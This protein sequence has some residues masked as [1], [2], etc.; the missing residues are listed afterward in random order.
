MCKYR[1]GAEQDS[2]TLF[3]HGVYILYCRKNIRKAS[4]KEKLWKEKSSVN[5]RSLINTC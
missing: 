4:E 2:P 5:I 3:P 1:D